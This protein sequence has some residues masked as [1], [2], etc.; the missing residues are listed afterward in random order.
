MLAYESMAYVLVGRAGREARVDGWK[1]R[2]K[3][4][5]GRGSIGEE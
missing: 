3:E 1:G 2:K 4:E 5:E